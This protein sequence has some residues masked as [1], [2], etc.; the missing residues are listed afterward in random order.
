[1]SAVME[2]DYDT[3]RGVYPLIKSIDKSVRKVNDDLYDFRRE[4]NYRLN[5]LEA[6]Q[7]VQGEAILALQKDTEILKN[8]VSELKSEV[9]ELNRNVSDIKGDI[10]ELLGKFGEVQAKF[11]WGLIILGTIV[12]LIQFLK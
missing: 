1:M 6:T 2:Y 10:R 11:N 5:T 8:D 9:K 3:E 7:K 12:T 4:T